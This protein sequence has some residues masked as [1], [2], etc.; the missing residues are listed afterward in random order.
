MA[1]TATVNCTNSKYT[2]SGGSWYGST[3]TDM[4]IG[5]SSDNEYVTRLT[6]P[7]LSTYSGISSVKLFVYRVNDGYSTRD[8]TWNASY[9]SSDAISAVGTNVGNF[10]VSNKSW[11]SISMPE[12]FVNNPPQDTF[13]IRLQHGEGS[14]SYG[15]IANYASANKPYLEVTYADGT[16]MRYNGS[17]WVECEMYRY[18]GSK[19]VQVKPYRYNGSGW[20]ECGGG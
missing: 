9:T 10:T 13:Y 7:K 8:K 4:C 16:V 6:F 11:G 19:W 17:S 2:W 12:A 20:T 14:N 3:S 5:K 18:D 15:E 1:K